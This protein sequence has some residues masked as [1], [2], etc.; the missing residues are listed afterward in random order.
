STR[1]RWAR[2]TSTRRRAISCTAGSRTRSS[3]RARQRARRRRSLTSSACGAPSPT[4]RSW[5]AV[6]SPP[7]RSRSSYR[8]PTASSLAPRGSEPATCGCRSS[9]HAW[10]S[11]LRR[12]AAASLLGVF[13]AA[14]CGTVLTPDPRLAAIERE[15]GALFLVGF[16]GTKAAGNADLTRLLCE[17]RVG[18]VLL[19]GRNIVDSDQLTRLTGAIASQSTAC[20]SR[21]LFVA[22]DAEGGNVMRLAPE[23]GW[24]A[25]FSAQELGETN[26]FTLT[27]LEARRIGAMLRAA[28]I[29]WDLAPVIDVGYNP[30]NPV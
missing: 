29:N 28:G 12:L 27:E 17:L 30:A 24:P 2:S 25:T 19:L 6:G 15:L 10:R 8:W 26:D 23:F 5:S 7:R 20:T 4:F 3:F 16:R 9:A 11:A 18:G 1:Y 21:K 22:V 14:G 13:L